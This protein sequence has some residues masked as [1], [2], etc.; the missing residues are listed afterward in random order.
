MAFRQATAGAALDA[1][2]IAHWTVPEAATRL[3]FV[4]GHARRTGAASIESRRCHGSNAAGRCRRATATRCSS[5]PRP[6]RRFRAR[7]VHRAQHRTALHD[8]AMIVVP[9]DAQCR[10]PRRSI[11]CSS[12][13]RQGRRQLPALPVVAEHGAAVTVIEDFVALHEERVLH[14]RGDRDRAGRRSARAPHPGAARK[15]QEAFHIATLRGV[16][17]DGSRVSSVSV[18]LGARISRNN[19][20]VLPGGRG[21]PMRDRRPGAD[22]RRQLADT[23]TLRSTMRSRTA[24]AG[25]CTSASSTAP[26]ARCSTATSWSGP[27]RSAPI[28][29]S[30]AATCSC[31]RRRTSTRSR[32]SRSSRTT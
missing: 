23:H 11:C 13:R 21:R 16:A 20:N 22:R 25:S 27:A 31:R 24:R 7:P 1:S 5:A 4:D 17:G 29:R 8:G 18:A 9:R 30:R 6:A 2:A 32:S 28:R 15:R 10:S 12:R 26:R 19:L 3:V 14:Q